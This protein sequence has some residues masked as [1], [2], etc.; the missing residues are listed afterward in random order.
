MGT[1]NLTAVVLDGEYKVAQYCQWDGYPSGQ[2][3][4]IAKFIEKEMNFKKFKKAVSN[5][6]FITEEEVGNLWKEAGADSSGMVSMDV[7]DSFKEKHPQLH[8]DT[9]AEVLK[10]IQEHNGLKL[11]NEIEFA[12]DSLFCEWAYVLDLDMKV[13]EIYRGFNVR[14]LNKKE[15][16]NFLREKIRKPSENEPNRRYYPVRLYKKAPFSKVTEKWMES[17]E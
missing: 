2:G 4:T 1:R 17:L 7:S 13:L 9:G 15:R 10:M 8:R 11:H 14:G 12:A 3:A 16:F 5:C 6:R